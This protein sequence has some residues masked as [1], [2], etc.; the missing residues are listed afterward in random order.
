MRV[1]RQ[2]EQIDQAFTAASSEARA[3]FGQGECFIERYLETSRH[4]ETQCL[5]DSQG[6]VAVLSTRDCTLQRRHQKLVE[7]AP[8][9]DLPPG[10]GQALAQCSR[11]ILSQ[12]S[13]LGA[14][15]CEFLVY[16]D[17]AV[18]HHR[19]AG[20]ADGLPEHWDGWRFAFLEVNTRLQVEHPVTEEIT[21]IDLVGEQLRIANGQALGYQTVE[22]TGHAIELRINGEDPMADFM[23]SPAV[24]SQ[25]QLPGGPGVRCDFGYDTNM[26][27]SG[28]FD[29]L[30]GKVIVRGSNR[31]N[32]LARARRALDETIVAGP[33][34]VTHFLR[35]L[36]DQVEFTDP[37]Q[38]HTRWIE[39]SFAPRYR[40]MVLTKAPGL[41]TIQQA[42]TVGS[43]LP[44]L[45]TEHLVVEVAG[46][47]F[48][49]LVPS[50]LANAAV[51]PARRPPR[52]SVRPAP[53]VGSGSITAPMQGTIVRLAVSEGQTVEQGELL[54]VLEAM[55][56]EQ[57]ITAP[58]AGVVQNLT[59]TVGSVV[60]AGTPL[61]SIE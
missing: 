29:S 55:K 11:S 37:S 6:T 23:P 34:T 35:T 32:A 16:K 57:P 20:R 59:A 43:A 2:K 50:S 40:Q 47:R 7:E 9:A 15:T 51:A 18:A 5:V 53:A 25:L 61:C 36:L 58:R 54:L 3:S 60:P 45:A 14:A 38:L 42:Q 31:A 33:A 27:L 30:I 22:A 26:A 52:R 19:A 56:M 28:S 8:A 48:E 1:V 49:V 13:Y 21:G 39:E 24:I 17:D 12:A 10:L 46:K 4:I 41:P 44:E